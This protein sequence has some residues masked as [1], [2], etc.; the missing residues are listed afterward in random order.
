MEPCGV[1]ARRDEADDGRA[2]TALGAPSDIHWAMTSPYG[3]FIQTVPV[4][5]CAS[6]SVL[7]REVALALRGRVE[8]ADVEVEPEL[9]VDDVEEVLRRRP[10]VRPA[11]LVGELA[12]A[13]V[14]G[15]DAVPRLR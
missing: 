14:Q 12:A 13:S 7:G 15:R 8:S 1:R 11:L 4:H 2:G 5:S 3:G 10:L 6:P 9:G